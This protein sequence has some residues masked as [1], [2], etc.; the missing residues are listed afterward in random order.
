M[1]IHVLTALSLV[2]MLGLLAGCGKD[3]PED[4][5][6]ETDVEL[7]ETNPEEFAKEQQEALE[8]AQ[9]ETEAKVEAAAGEAEKTM[10]DMQSRVEKI[11]ADAKKLMDAKEYENALR[12]I[13]E[14]LAIE[15]LTETQR[16]MLEG[17]LAQVRKAM[18]SGAADDAKKK[19]GDMLKK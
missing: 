3:S 8:A 13:Q 7:Q 18:T 19:L 12:K 11:A 2:L 10:S 5:V 15:G 16:K 14:G 17:L 6:E 1:R 4:A 9:A